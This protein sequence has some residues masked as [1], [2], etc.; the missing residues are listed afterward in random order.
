MKQT[1]KKNHGSH[2]EGRNFVLLWFS[3][4]PDRDRCLYTYQEGLPL[5]KRAKDHP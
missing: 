5:A 2:V 3:E 4:P 1:E